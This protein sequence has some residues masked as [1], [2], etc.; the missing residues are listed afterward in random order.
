MIYIELLIGSNKCSVLEQV[1]AWHLSALSFPAN[2]LFLHYF[3]S[4]FVLPTNW[5]LF[6][7]SAFVT[8][9]TA[10]VNVHSLFIHCLRQIRFLVLIT[11]NNYLS[12][13]TLL[14]SFICSLSVLYPVDRFNL[15][16]SSS[17]PRMKSLQSSVILRSQ[18]PRL[19]SI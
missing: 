11:Y 19:N 1:F 6:L 13:P 16:Y 2:L 17:H 7:S 12:S 4:T 14:N 5:Y 10:Y 18:N 9:S 8:S 3:R 15:F